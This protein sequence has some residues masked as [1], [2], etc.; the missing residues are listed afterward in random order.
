MR[1]TWWMV[2]CAGLVASANACGDSENQ[3][4]SGGT[5]D[6]A[7]SSSSGGALTDASVPP[8][9]GE[10]SSSS[11]GSPSDG[12][13]AGPTGLRFGTNAHPRQG[14]PSNDV[15][16]VMLDLQSLGLRHLRIDVGKAGDAPLMNQVIAAASAISVEVTPDIVLGS[17][18]GA[19]ATPASNYADAHARAESIVATAPGVR[20]WEC[21]NEYNIH[22]MKAGTTGAAPADYDPAKIVLAREWLRGCAD[23]VHAANPANRV[24]VNY[25]GFKGYGFLLALWNGPQPDGGDN[26]RWDISSIHHY[27]VKSNCMGDLESLGGKNVFEIVHGLGVPIWITEFHDNQC[28]TLGD[29]TAA[30]SGAG[31]VAFM[32]RLVDI[33]AQY[34]IETADIY[35]LYDQGS[36]SDLGIYNGFWT[37]KR[38][39]EKTAFSDPVRAFLTAH[40]NP[41]H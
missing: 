23:A 32:T 27:N 8:D 39:S 28:S 14:A 5:P 1:S 16:Q 21:G 22:S 29:E 36:G 30:Q 3:D 15:P 34:D 4:P 6:A 40:G 35:Q 18:Y 31:N 38:G 24:V 17:I 41:A 2:A 20:T 26:L 13:D 19:G 7:A 10:S 9:A 11:G 12:G 25:S 37:P 33:A